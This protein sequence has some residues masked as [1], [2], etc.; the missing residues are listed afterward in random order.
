MFTRTLVAAIAVS[1]IASLPA[2][3]FPW[4]F[5]PAKQGGVLKNNQ[6]KDDKNKKQAPGQNNQ[7]DDGQQNQKD[8]GQQ[9]QKDDGRQNQK[10][11]GQQNQ[12]NGGGNKA[13][14]AQKGD[15]PKLKAVP[16]PKK[17]DEPKLKAVPKKG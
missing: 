3:A 2:V 17:G 1:L 6:A 5:P 7:K 15:N 13:A 4:L 9:N 8:D 10:D 11:D 16:L 12:N 14:P